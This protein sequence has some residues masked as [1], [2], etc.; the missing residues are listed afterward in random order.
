MPRRFAGTMMPC[1]SCQGDIDVPAKVAGSAAGGPNGANT[2]LLADE[3]GELQPAPATTELEAPAAATDE[4]KPQSATRP[5][6]VRAT[7][8]SGKVAK[9]IAAGADRPV[10]Q[11]AADGKLPELKLDEGPEKSRTQEKSA[12]SNPLLL[13]FALIASLGLSGLMLFTD[14]EPGASNTDRTRQARSAIEQQFFGDTTKPLVPFQVLLREA[15]QAHSRGDRR[16]ERETYQRVLE[17]LRA[18]QR[19]GFSSVT[20]SQVEDKRLE[21]LISELLNDN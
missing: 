16:A 6:P 12:G 19:I 2:V 11:F 18:E 20:G 13:V 9:F 8:Q 3:P 17:L 14:F 10:V 7:T 1:P 5:K 15:Q 21:E 4:S